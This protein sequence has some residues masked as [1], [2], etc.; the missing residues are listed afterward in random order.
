MPTRQPQLW[1]IAGPNGAGKTTLVAD[2]VATRLPVVNPDDIAADL[3][4]LDGRLDERQAGMI[5]LRRRTDL[6]ARRE[7]FAVET[8]LTG[9]SAMRLIG[10][11][12]TAGYKITLVFVGL[13]SVDLS[14]QR[15][16]D[17]VDAGGHPVPVSALERRYPDAL[18]HLA[19]AMQA[20]DRT[21]VLDNSGTRRRLLLSVEEGRTRFLAL[22]LPAWFRQSLPDHG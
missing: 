18:A 16:V 10:Q 12:R 1:V 17:R 13:A 19:A 5:A 22:D 7:S 6:L 8:T 3:P 14:M 4:R 11:A 20:A 9:H 15:V 2:R 21:F